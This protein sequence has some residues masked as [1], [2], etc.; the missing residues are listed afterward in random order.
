M[1]KIY[2]LLSVITAFLVFIG[3]QAELFSVTEKISPLNMEKASEEQTQSLSP[4]RK[5]LV[6]YFAY[7]GNTREIANQIHTSVRGIFSR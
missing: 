7:S 5:I 2:F 3:V 6:V 4:A 1:K